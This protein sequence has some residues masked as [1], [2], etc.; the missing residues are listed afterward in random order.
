VYWEGALKG[1][2]SLVSLWNE[3]QH[4]WQHAELL[5]NNEAT[6][7]H[8]PMEARRFAVIDTIWRNIVADTRHFPNLIEISQRVGLAGRLEDA[9]CFFWAIF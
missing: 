5:F 1:V 6:V 3:V 9:R 7:R 2:R 8:M 4:R